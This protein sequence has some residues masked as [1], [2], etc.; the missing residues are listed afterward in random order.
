MALPGAIMTEER[1][2]ELERTRCTRVYISHDDVPE[3]ITE[4]RSLQAEVKDWTSAACAAVWL[5][6]SGVKCGE[7]TVAR[8]RLN[9][10]LAENTRLQAEV[11]RLRQVFEAAKEYCGLCADE[12]WINR[13]DTSCADDWEP[14]WN[15]LLESVLAVDSAKAKE[16]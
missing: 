4:I 8:D 5:V 11:S 1:L 9:D 16:E 12:E 3:L 13:N 7:I 2:A 15:R 10:I 14:L 6:P